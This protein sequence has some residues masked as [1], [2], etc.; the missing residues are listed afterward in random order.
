MFKTCNHLICSITRWELL[1]VYFGEGFL[2]NRHFLWNKVKRYL[3]LKIS[4]WRLMIFISVGEWV[5]VM[6]LSRYDAMFAATMIY[7]VTRDV[8]VFKPLI[9]HISPVQNC[10]WFMIKPFSSLLC[11]PVHIGMF[12]GSNGI[13]GSPYLVEQYQLNINGY[14]RKFLY[15]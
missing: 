13:F 3:P 7:S 2:L 5:W 1:G 4:F 10:H 8:S 11:V 15:M 9:G 12:I 14:V 6:L